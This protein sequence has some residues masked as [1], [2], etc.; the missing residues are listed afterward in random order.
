MTSSG[1]EYLIT[2]QNQIKRRQRIVTWISIISF[3]GSGA[4]AI[5]PVLTELANPKKPQEAVE[6]QEYKLAQQ[7]RG[8][9][10]V[11]QREPEN[12]VALE[13]LVMVRLRMNDAQGA[14]PPLEKLVKLRPE[15]QDYKVLL[16]QIKGTLSKPES[17]QK[18]QPKVK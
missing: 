7:E 10:L 2:R 8:F 17:Q 13:G 3:F 4:F 5:V 12:Q 16:E 15:R 11:L 9:E 6:P 1:E 14:I 18:N